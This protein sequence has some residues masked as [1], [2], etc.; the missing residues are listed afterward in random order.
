MIGEPVF[1]VS[2]PVQSRFVRR[3][4]NVVAVALG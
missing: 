2:G 1:R 4:M 3:R